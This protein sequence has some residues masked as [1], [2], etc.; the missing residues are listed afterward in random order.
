MY[1]SHHMLGKHIMSKC[2]ILNSGTDNA[3]VFFVFC[4]FAFS[5]LCILHLCMCW[6]Q[7][8]RKFLFGSRSWFH[9]RYSHCLLPSRCILLFHC[10]L[11]FQ[12]I[13]PYFCHYTAT[14][15]LLSTMHGEGS[16]TRWAYKAMEGRLVASFH[17]FSAWKKLVGNGRGQMG[18]R[19]I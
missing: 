13:L 2:L 18:G 15:L 8:V 4:I 14:L 9:F 1:L 3:F 19:A 16:T 5:C 7:A 17:L 12:C 10:I 6:M 11:L